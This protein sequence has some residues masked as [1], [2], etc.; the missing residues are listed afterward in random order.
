MLQTRESRPDRPDR[1]A[2]RKE[3][4]NFTNSSADFSASPDLAALLDAIWRAKRAAKRSPLPME[5]RYPHLTSGQIRALKAEIRRMKDQD[6]RDRA[7]LVA[8]AQLLTGAND[9]HMRAAARRV[10]ALDGDAVD[11]RMLRARPDGRGKR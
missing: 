11:N 5:E 4:T 10:L 9:P 7:A 2:S 1:A 8:R 6:R 3:I